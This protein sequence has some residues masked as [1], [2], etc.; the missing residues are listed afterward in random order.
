MSTTDVPAVPTAEIVETHGATLT[1]AHRCDRC[2]AQAYVEVEIFDKGQAHELYGLAEGVDSGYFDKIEG[3]PKRALLFCKH[4]FTAHTDAL[5]EQ[6][7]RIVDDTGV[8]TAEA[9][10]ARTF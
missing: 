4:H 9:D 6:A 2:G 3:P 7:S 1:A 10:A 5:K 8:L